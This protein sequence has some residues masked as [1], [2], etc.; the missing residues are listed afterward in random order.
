MEVSGQLCSLAL[1]KTSRYPLEGGVGWAPNLSG[2]G[3]ENKIPY[4]P[5]PGIEA[6]TS[7]P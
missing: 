6:W 7:S 5:L 1:R 4:L 2:C 3:G